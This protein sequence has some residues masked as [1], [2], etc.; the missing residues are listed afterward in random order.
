MKGTTQMTGDH[1]EKAKN[2]PVDEARSGAAPV[3]PAAPAPAA[4]PAYATI[5]DVMKVQLKAATI[6]EARPH[7]KG[8]KLMVLQL[9][10]GAGERRQIMAGIRQ[11]YAAEQLV[12]K[13]VVVIANLAPRQMMGEW[14]NGMLLAATDQATG[15]VIIVSPSEVVAPGSVVK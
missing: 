6:V 11:H 2:P 15:R 9:D 5:D 3:A 7:V 1:D 8:D 10:M 13:Q 14:S 4:T 12:G